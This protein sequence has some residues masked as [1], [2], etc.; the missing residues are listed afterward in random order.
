MTAKMKKFQDEID[1]WMWVDSYFDRIAM[2]SGKPTC[3]EYIYFTNSQSAPVSGGTKCL[4]DGN[5]LIA[6]A[7]VVRDDANWS[8]ATLCEYGGDAE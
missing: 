2:R 8:V 7:T 3:T 5:N 6:Q 1:A 4:W